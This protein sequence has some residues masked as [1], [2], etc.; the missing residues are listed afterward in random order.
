MK[1]I[2]SLVIVCMMLS[3]CFAAVYADENKISASFIYVA[4]NGDDAASGSIEAPFK[5][6]AAAVKKAE[7]MDGTVV[8][9]LR[10]GVY[11]MT[12]TV[13]MTAD[14]SDIVIRSYPGEEAMVTG[15]TVIPFSSF[16][17]CTDKEFLDALLVKSAKDKVISANLRELGVSDFGEIRIQGFFGDAEN[18]GYAPTL[19]YNDKAL[20]IARYPN[21]DYLYTD[22]IIRD[23]SDKELYFSKLNQIEYTVTDKRYQKWSKEDVWCTAYFRHDWA[24]CTA[25]AEF[26]EMDTVIGYTGS[27]YYAV[28][29]RRLYYFNVPE[30]LDVPGEWYL[31]RETGM[32]Y[33]IPVDGMTGSDELVFNSY[34]KNFF[35]VKGA[36]NIRFEGIRFSG[37]CAKGIEVTECDGVVINNC[38]FT[39]IGDVAVDF[40]KCY[41][42]G[43]E[44]SHLHDLGSWGIYLR[45][46][47]DRI[48]LVS[49][50]CFVI[51]THIEAFSQYR[52]TYCPGIQVYNDV[53]SVI[54][55]CEIHDAPHFAIRY[56]ANEMVIEYCDIYDVCQDTA[57][58][59]AVYTGNR[60]ETRGNQ[61]RYNYFHD[62]KIIDTTTGM[63]MQAVYLDDMHAATKVFGNVFYRVDSVALLGGG[64]Y[65][66]FSNNLM[67]D[68][69]KPLVFDA[70]A[71][72]YDWVNMSG[73]NNALAA[74]PYTEG[75]WAE[76]YPELVGIKDDEPEIPKHNVIKNNVIYRT[77]QISVRPLVSQHG[78]I[79]DAVEISNTKGFVDYGKDFT[80]KEDSEVFKKIPAFENIPFEKIGR[81]EYKAEDNYAEKIA[82]KPDDGSIKVLLNGNKIDFADVAPQ[83][84]NDRTMV[85]LRAIF[86]ALGATVEWDDTTK[87]VTA[88]K[89]DV[90]IKMTIGADSFMRNDE[91]VSLDSP[92]TIVDSRTL[93]PVRA[94][95]E[96]FG[97]AV[98][99]IAE[100]KTVTITD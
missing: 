8:I 87:T 82:D 92:A 47:G 4:E 89:G 45:E 7:G 72:E 54:S 55:N 44:N 86:E 38:E 28:A 70:R 32:L 60:W 6:I 24:D 34:N 69:N 91:T 68:C 63:Q 13:E 67:L 62:L 30:E 75:V 41:R 2:I 78:S 98:G 16:E 17:K 40:S 21:D 26:T 83:I 25:P 95:A 99:W 88:V 19:T 77:P 14:S 29:N 76:K 43:V 80:L 18:Q 100:T 46:C 35:D 22:S 84:I 93:V 9:N 53:G 39:G 65:N 3:S 58:S 73:I 20:T 96:S 74:V 52:K 66:E 5:S 10:G 85:P 49:G 37:T 71:V 81:Y 42:S 23:G 27:G 51:N 79:E 61:I 15:G 50:E 90:T 48:N 31:D 12:D 11:Q 64:R 33:M 57:D 97:L 36:K 1:R 94:I 59:G 56:E